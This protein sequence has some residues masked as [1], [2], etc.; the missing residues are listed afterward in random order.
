MESLAIRQRGA[1]E[2]SSVCKA[3]Y[4]RVTIQYGW[5]KDMDEAFLDLQKALSAYTQNDDIEE[6]NISQFDPNAT[7]IMIIGLYHPEIKDFNELRKTAENQVRNELIRLEGIADVTIA[8]QQEKEVIIDT[9]P[10]LLTSYGLT[11]EQLVTKIQNYNRSVSGGSIEELGKKYIIK[12]TSIVKDV[13]DIENIVVGYT[14]RTQQSD[15]VQSGTATT[16]L[17]ASEKVPILLK[18]VASVQAHDNDASNIVRINQKRSLGLSI[19]K[20]TKFNT[21]AAVN[22]L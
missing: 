8:G 18:E 20:E 14:S 6:L 9:D 13:E 7:P 22:E 15:S 1:V 21:I 11:V 17:P 5:E 19:Y 4:G 2:V 10:N 3:G 12:G 16:N